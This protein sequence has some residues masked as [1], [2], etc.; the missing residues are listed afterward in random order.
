MSLVKKESIREALAAA[1]ARN[2]ELSELEIR[3]CVAQSLSL[4]VE[5]VDEVAEESKAVAAC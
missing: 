3:A 5:A 2:L 4:P 1:R